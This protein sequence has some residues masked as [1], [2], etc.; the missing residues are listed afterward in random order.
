M[1]AEENKE[2]TISLKVA[3]QIRNVRLKIYFMNSALIHMMGEC[4]GE[5]LILG[6]QLIL[7]D[8]EKDLENIV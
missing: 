4:P 8:M 6:A 5:E 1:S 2:K 3:E 7:S